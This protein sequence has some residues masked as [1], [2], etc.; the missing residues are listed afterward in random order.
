MTN[1]SC[2]KCSGKYVIPVRSGAIKERVLSLLYT[3]LFRCQLSGYHFRFIHWGVKYLRVHEDYREYERLP[4]NSPVAFAGDGVDDKG[5]MADI[6]MGGC[7]IQANT[8][9]EKG[10]I[11]HMSLHISNELPP[12]TVDAAVVRNVSLSRVG[13]EFLKFRQTERERLQLFIR[14]TSEKVKLREQLLEKER[15]AAIGASASK[16][17]HEIGNPLNGM[18]LTVQLLERRLAKSAETLDQDAKSKILNLKNE[19]TRL[20]SLIG[21][22]RAAS[23]REKY[24][25][26]STSLDGLVRQIIEMENENYRALGIQ[27]QLHFPADFPLVHADPD[28]LKQALL[29]LFKNAVEAM[30]HGGILTLRG[31]YLRE[32]V[33]LEIIDSGDGIPQG[34]DIFA[35]FTTTKAKGTGLGMMTVRQ[36]VLAHEGTISYTTETGKGTTFTVTLPLCGA[37]CF[38]VTPEEPGIKTADRL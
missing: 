15:L 8:Q 23:R 16:L 18:Y 2:P 24:I 12:V 37:Y 28:R 27:V 31:L 36:I 4:T 33:G 13:L 29:N 35:P 21:E 17:V 11:V 3:Y 26:R 14:D 38:T 6:S 9:L 1:P 25:F 20:N 10:D 30:P 19:I 5:S 32:R 34:I 22:F 7:T